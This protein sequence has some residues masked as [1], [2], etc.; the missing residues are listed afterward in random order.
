MP[1]NP[2]IEL[3]GDLTLELREALLQVPGVQGEGGANH[4][5][6]HHERFPFDT[7]LRLL[8][9][10]RPVRLQVLTRKSSSPRDLREAALRL[11]SVSNSPGEIPS[12]PLIAAPS[13]GARAR[14]FLREQG[15][16]Y[17]DRG[18]SLYLQLPW[19]VYWIDRPPPPSARRKRQDLFRGRATQV[20][21]ALLLEPDR[22]WHVSDLAPR[23]EVSPYLALQVCAYLEDQLWM[24]RHG[25]GPRR[26]RRLCEPG[27]L[28]DAWAEAYSL[29]RY[30]FQR[31]Y[32]WTQSPK[33]LLELVGAALEGGG[34]EYALT[35]AAG[36]A[37]VAPFATSV[38][39][40]TFIIPESVPLPEIAEA[41]KLRPVE[42][43]ENIAFLVTRERAPLLFR[44][45]LGDVWVA[46][47]IQLYLDLYAW[48]Q[49]GREQA[50]HLRSERLPF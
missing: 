26:V 39:R 5:L 22:P 49:R 40:L 42:D 31:Y 18:G 8:V 29:D 34:V 10:G 7:E 35:L 23:A 6:S 11:E 45:R 41:A 36:A 50:Q 27:K 47:A 19:A 46:S 2:I 15:I 16:G 44:Q 14:E 3:D 12:V 43:G 4:F 20:L 13:I 33:A 48:P 17:W 9:A 30:R 24:E 32:R 37:L 38:E 21:H 25:R 1:S 28:L